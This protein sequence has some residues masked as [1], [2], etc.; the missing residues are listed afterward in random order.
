MLG[1]WPA[2]LTGS[3]ALTAAGARDQDERVIHIVVD[4]RRRI[5][6]R[7]GVVVHYRTGLDAQVLWATRPPRVRVEAAL[8]DQAASA[9]TEPAAIATLTDAVGARLTTTSLLLAAA[10]QRSRL[11][12]RRLIEQVLVDIRDG[13][14][15]V[16]EHGYLTRVERAHGLPT[17]RRQAPTGAGRPG[18][19]DIDYPEYGLVIELD[20]RG[21]HSA[22]AD[23]DRDLER[24][25]DAVVEV[26]RLTLRLGWGQVM[27]RACSTAR[28][29]GKLLTA[30]GW[31]GQ[32]SPCPACPSPP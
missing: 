13:T 25:L 18:F 7:P 12:R 4:R 23:R 19:R 31:P 22:A 27:G 1:I 2:A 24:D 3:S 15:S 14:C 9:A 11:R 8:L 26:Q 16:L 21:H 29:V 28:K 17:P 20:G 30:R 10:S 32:V 6:P 5:T